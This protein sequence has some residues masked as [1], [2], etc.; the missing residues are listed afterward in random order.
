MTMANMHGDFVWY[1]LI[2]PDPD[3]AARF[4]GAVVGWTQKPSS[5]PGMDYREWAMG[6]APVGGTLALTDD[7][8]SAG[9]QPG[10]L[11]Y[12]HVNDIDGQIERLKT[13][14]ATI[15]TGPQDIPGVGR[16]AMIT[17]P[18]G[19]PLYVMTDTSG[20]TSTAFAKDMPKAGHC[21]WNELSTT[22]PAGAW[23]FYGSQFGWKKD[24]E[25]DM[26]PMGKYEFVKSDAMI[27][28]IMPK[29]P[30][31]PVPAWTFY[32]RVPDIDAAAGQIKA[33]GGTLLME[34]M[35]IPGGE[36]SLSA[37]DPHGAAFGLVGARIAS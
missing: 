16:F 31:M 8:R 26:G 20:V 10:W 3:G 33:N 4:Y 22:D 29:M 1:E 17:D 12:V 35:E 36:F 28:A 24:G 14:G 23:A 7:M 18:Q 21:A 25:L 37:L 2:T 11:G 34:P 6:E 19:V 32:F 9:A 30:E 15:M 5:T 13:A 27:G